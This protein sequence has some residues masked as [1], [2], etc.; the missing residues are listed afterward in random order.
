MQ[1]CLLKDSLKKVEGGSSVVERQ[2]R[3]RGSLGSNI[4]RCRFEASTFSFSPRCPSSLSCVNE[5]LAID[6]GG[7]MCSLRVV[8]A[9]WPNAPQRSR[10]GVG[11]SRSARVCRVK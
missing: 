1:R 5:Y 3:N 7:T 4:F 10:V 6:S 2:T 11:M 9:V 8:I